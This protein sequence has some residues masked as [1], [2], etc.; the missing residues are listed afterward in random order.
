MSGAKGIS[1]D[2]DDFAQRSRVN[3][4]E[5]DFAFNAGFFSDFDSRSQRS[6]WKLRT[7]IG[8]FAATGAGEAQNDSQGGQ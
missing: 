2:I 1:A 3:A 4:S 6:L 8:D 7:T 5:G